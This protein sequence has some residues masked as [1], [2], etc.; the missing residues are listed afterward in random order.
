MADAL[1]IKSEN[2]D[3]SLVEVKRIFEATEKT[4]HDLRAEVDSLKGKSADAVTADKLAKAE[5]EFKSRLEAEQKATLARLEKLEVEATK[6]KLGGAEPSD[7]DGAEYKAA[8]D[9]FVRKGVETEVKAMATDSNPDGGIMV[10]STMATQIQ[11]RLRRS[12]PVRAVA[13]IVSLNGT[14]EIPVE[15]GD[16][17]Y[18]WAGERQTRSETDSPTIDLIRIVQHEL[19]A[20]PRVSQRMLDDA[21]FNVE[22]FIGSRVS[23]RFARAEAA[24]FVAGDGVNKPKGFLAYATAA[25]ADASRAS[26]TLEHVGTGVSGDFAASNKADIFI[27]VFYKLHSD[28]QS[29]ASWMM[30]SSTAAAVAKLKDGD[31]TFLIQGLLN[32]D[33]SIA[34]TIMGRPLFIADDMP[35]IAANSLSIAV[36]DFSR[37]YTINDGPGVRVLRDPYSAKPFVI[38]YTTKRVGGG[39]SDFDAIKLIKFA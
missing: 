32:G 11:T 39:V 14:Y 34:R 8:F 31:G 1:E 5:A 7:N 12:S 3:A 21:A 33:G 28:Y 2:S 9:K 6:G 13:N 16:A 24:A 25:T 26:G 37:G 18:E 10:P 15:R 22:Q 20:A 4:L 17:G 27:D 35:V 38:F 19:S 29:N 23:D 30:A 36:G